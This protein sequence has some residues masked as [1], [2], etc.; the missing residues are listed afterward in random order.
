M[1]KIFSIIKYVEKKFNRININKK[2]LNLIK[3]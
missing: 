1:K 2:S 3:K